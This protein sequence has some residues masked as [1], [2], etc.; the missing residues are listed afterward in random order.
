MSPSELDLS[1]ESLSEAYLEG[2]LSPRELI[3]RLLVRSAETPEV[4]IHLMRAEEVEPYLVEIEQTEPGSLPLWGIPFAIKDNIDLAGIPT[5]AACPAYAYTP[6]EDAFVVRKLIEAGAIPVGKT[7]LDQFA[8]GLV[9]TRSPYGAVRN[10][11]DPA[12]ISGGSSSGSAAAVASGL[13]SFAL[14]TDTAGSGRVPA[15]FNNLIGVKPTRGR[16]STRGV[17]PACAS[18][19]CV[20]VL[21]LNLADADRITQL[22]GV[23]DAQDPWA[24]PLPEEFPTKAGKPFR[25]AVPVDEDQEFFGHGE[26]RIAYRNA[27]EQLR[28]AGGESISI[29]I[30]TFIEAAEL[31]YQGSWVA[32]RYLSARKLIDENPDALLPVTRA[33]I[34][35]GA[36]PRATHL[37][38]ELYRLQAL[39]REAEH[40]FEQVDCLL[41]PTAAFCPTLT[42]V[43]NDPVGVNTQLG[44]YTN[45]VNL[46]DL[47]AIAV[48]AGIAPAGLPFGV[49]LMGPAFSDAT[50]MELAA[51]YLAIETREAGATGFPMRVA[52]PAAPPRCAA[53]EFIEVAVCG[54]HLSGMPLNWQLTERGASLVLGSTTAP[55]Y[56]LYALAGGPPERPGLQRAESGGAAIEV[57]VWSVPAARFGDFVA[58]IPAPLGI[59]KLELAD[60][61]WV[62]GFICEPCGI[63]TATEITNLGSWRR[64]CAA[65]PPNP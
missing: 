56:R 7:N 19:D 44:Y 47:A 4:W 23:F 37:F 49:T 48:P 15:A 18:L 29:Q 25:F 5:T 58:G 57:E 36:E 59:G 34:S 41:L 14:G 3:T 62:S 9:G 54:A 12:Y 8:T 11:F 39:K 51:R 1:I 30:S 27:V 32:E 65:P 10:T 38:S 52:E 35:K 60:G 31:L 42:E 13:V 61:S 43:E 50:L 53:P 64:Y 24:R 6:D 28:Q 46:L 21:A 26:S 16:L 2:T 45:F 20:T 63:E 55:C 22:A 40:I 17:V 33:I